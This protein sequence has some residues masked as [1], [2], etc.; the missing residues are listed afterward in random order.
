MDEAR[1]VAALQEAV[2]HSEVVRQQL[3]FYVT[4]RIDPEAKSTLLEAV[5]AEEELQVFNNRYHHFMYLGLRLSFENLISWL[6]TRGHEVGPVRAVEDL[7][8]YLVE[9][10]I[11][12]DEVVAL[13]GIAVDERVDLGEGI[14][15][16]RDG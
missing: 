3:P 16:Q 6:V 13:A 15:R 7:K 1:L 8:R 14:W 4:P 5:R 10:Q 9:E 12:V 11:I 2:A